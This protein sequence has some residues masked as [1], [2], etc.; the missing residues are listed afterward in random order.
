MLHA[1]QH[2]LNDS[3]VWLP[4]SNTQYSNNM[5]MP[6]NAHR[7]VFGCL[8]LSF[9]RFCAILWIDVDF[10][11]SWNDS[12]VTYK[13]IKKKNCTNLRRMRVL[14]NV[15]ICV[16]VTVVSVVQNELNF[17]SSNKLQFATFMLWDK[18]NAYRKL[19]TEKSPAHQRSECKIWTWQQQQQ[20]FTELP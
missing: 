3:R 6:K 16:Y 12:I 18:Q 1:H 14:P 8:S 9:V 7:L 15:C 11:A 2:N 19:L 20:T 5:C 10:I 17:D 13:L 4:S